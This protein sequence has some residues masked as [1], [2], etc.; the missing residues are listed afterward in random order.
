MARMEM[1]YNM[2][3]REALRVHFGSG[4]FE[5]AFLKFYNWNVNICTQ[6]IVFHHCYIFIS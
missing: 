3:K 5:M 2:D 4:S 1:D 6:D